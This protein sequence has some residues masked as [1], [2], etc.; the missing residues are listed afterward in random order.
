MK[1]LPDFQSLAL[2]RKG[3][4]ENLNKLLIPIIDQQ[5]LTNKPDSYY[6]EW[7]TRCIFN[8]G[9]Y[10]SVITKKWP[11][12]REAFL[13]FD[14]NTLAFQDEDFWIELVKDKRIV[15]HMKKISAVRANI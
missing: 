1:T 11:D 10:W 13:G 2:K 8:A 12:F 5:E 14:V 9:F 6:L 15:R 3:S 7:M 4:Q